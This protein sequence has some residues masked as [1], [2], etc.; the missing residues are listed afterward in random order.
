[1]DATTYRC[2]HCGAADH[3]RVESYSTAR[4]GS[5]APRRRHKRRKP[6]RKIKRTRKW[7]EKLRLGDIFHINQTTRTGSLA[8]F[9]KNLEFEDAFLASRTPRRSRHGKGW[10]VG[11]P[12]W[13]CHEIAE[14]LGIIEG[15]AQTS[16]DMERAASE[17]LEAMIGEE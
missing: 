3:S 5:P 1:M 14:R 10:R 11:E 2:P 6:I 13:E 9:K 15:S 8:Q 17:R 4:R 16:A 12:C 7:H